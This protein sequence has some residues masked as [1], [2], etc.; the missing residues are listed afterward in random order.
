V[1]TGSREENASKQTTRASVLIQSE[2]IRLQRN[3]N[4]GGAFPFRT[5]FAGVFAGLRSPDSSLD[6]IY[7][8]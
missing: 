5:R 1:V 2:P 3:S 7:L 6:K 4:A 8:H